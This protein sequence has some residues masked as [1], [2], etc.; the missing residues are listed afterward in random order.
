M[1]FWPSLLM[2][3]T[4]WS[5]VAAH[6]ESRYRVVLVDSPGHGESDPLVRKFAFDECAR[7][8]AELLDGLEIAKT[9]F[10][11][12]SWGAMIGGTF[13]ARHPK[14]VVASVL[15]NGTASEAGLRQKLEYFAL[16]RIVR[17]MG[18]VRGPLM[19]SVT[20]A[21]LGPTSL[22]EKPE[23]VRTIRE[24]VARAHVTSS[25]LAVESV[26]SARPDQHALLATIRSPVYVVAGE[27]DPTFSLA[28]TQRMAAAIPGAE[29]HVMPRTGH[30]AGLERPTEVAALIDGFLARVLP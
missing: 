19:R 14:R 9:I 16:T 13:A 15:M 30:L 2:D 1:M 28:E 12:N 24:T 10:V 21:F 27:E 11:G 25:I 26:V 23:A 7:C 4:M 3:G 20:R 29:F 17:A 22:R 18:G 5:S 8:I 6:F